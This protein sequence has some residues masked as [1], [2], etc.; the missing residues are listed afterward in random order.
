MANLHVNLAFSADTGKAKAQIQELQT[1]LSKIAYTGTTSNSLTGTMQKDIQAASSAAKDLQFHLNNAFNTTTGKF[2][3]SLLDR[4]LK[5]SGANITDLSTKLLG[6]G[7]TGQQAFMKL[8][9]SISLADQPMFRISN[10]MKEFAVTMKNT[11]KWQLSSSMLHGFMGAIQSAYGYAQDL[12]KSLTDIRIVTGYSADQMAV[13]A[14]RANKAAKSLSTTTTD[15]TNASLI[16][17]QQGLSD[18]EVAE[19]T[20]VT[21]KMANAAGESAQ[22]VSDQ[23]TAVWNNFYDGSKSLEYY[24]DVMTALG[25]ATASS[26]DEISEGLSK[27]AAVA[28]TVGLSYEY[29]TAAL[30]TITS[31]TR[32]SAD[33]VGNALKTLFARI[34]GLKLGETLEDGVNLNKYSEALDKA[35]I[36]IFESNGELKAMDDILTELASRWDTMSN[37]QQVALAQTVA[38][39][40]Q[41]TQLIALMENWDNG[42]AD[43]MMAN[44]RTIEGSEGALNEQADIYAQSWEAASKRVQ[45]AAQGIYQSLLD[46]DFFITLNNGFANLLGGIDA[47]IDG[48]GGLKTILISIAGVVMS[49]FANKIPAALDTLKYNLEVVTKGSQKAYERIQNQMNAATE[50]AFNKFNQTAGQQGIQKDSAMG[51]AIEQANELTAARN[52][53]AM[54]SDRMSAS[55]R[56]AADVQLGLIAAQQ[57]EVVALKEK[58]EALRASIELQR[59][60]IRN[61][62]VDSTSKSKSLKSSEEMSSLFLQY[63]DMLQNA[64]ERAGQILTIP[65]ADRTQRQSDNLTRLNA[66][67]EQYEQLTTATYNFSRNYQDAMQQVDST[68]NRIGQSLFQAFSSETFD[69]STE[70]VIQFSQEFRYAFDAIE[71]TLLNTNLDFNDSLNIQ[72]VQQQLKALQNTIPETVQQATGLDMAFNRVFSAMNEAELLDAFEYLQNDLANCTIEGNR[73]QTVLE[74]LYGRPISQISSDMRTLAANT[75]LANQKASILK[76][77]LAEF[78]PTHIVRMSEAMGALAGLM[79][80]IVTIGNSIKSIITSLGNPDLSGWEKFSA[81]LTGFSM[82]IPAVISGLRNATIA[83]EFLSGSFK[84]SALAM[85]ADAAGKTTNVVATKLLTAANTALNASFGPL[86]IIIA[87]IAAAILVAVLAFKALK[88]VIDAIH[89]SSFEGQLEAAEEATRGMAT[90]AEDATAAYQELLSTISGYDSAISALEGL[91]VGTQEFTN[92]LITA[93]EKAWELIDAYGLIQGQDWDYGENG[94]IIINDEAKNRITDQANE[95][96]EDAVVAASAAEI[97]EA[98]A[99]YNLSQSKAGMVGYDIQQGNLNDKVLYDA[100]GLTN[101]SFEHLK[102]QVQFDEYGN[103]ES[104]GVEIGDAVAQA[105]YGKDYDALDTSQLEYINNNIFKYLDEIEAMYGDYANLN[106]VSQNQRQKMISTSLS[107]EEAYQQTAWKGLI[108]E[109]LDKQ[110]DTEKARQDELFAA[111]TD[112]QVASDFAKYLTDQG[113]IQ[114]DDGKVYKK[115]ED[116]TQGDEVTNLSNLSADAQRNILATVEAMRTLEDQGVAMAEG[117]NQVASTMS[118]EEA[119]MADALINNNLGALTEEQIQQLKAAGDIK[120]EDLFDPQTLAAIRNNPVLNAALEG[121]LADLEKSVAEWE[122]PPFDLESWKADYAKKMDIINGLETGDEISAEDYALLGDEYAQYFQVQADGTAILIAKA[123]ELRA[124]AQ[125]IETDKLADD[126]R[127]K[128]DTIDEMNE[129]DIITDSGRT[130]DFNAAHN[131]ATRGTLH[132]TWDEAYINSV[133]EALGTSYTTVQEANAAYNEYVGSLSDSQQTLA[134]TADS[135]NDLD[136]MFAD[137]LI[138]MEQWSEATKGTVIKEAIAEGFEADEIINYAE[139]L[140]DAY[141]AT[142]ETE[143]EAYRLALAHKKQQKGLDALADGYEDWFKKMKSNG[144]DAVDALTEMQDA[145]ADILD[146]SKDDMKFLDKDFFLENEQLIKDA[147]TK[148]GEYIDQLREKASDEIIAKVTADLDETKAAE[149]TSKLQDLRT[150]AQLTLDGDPVTIGT[151]I[152]N[153]AAFDGLQELLNQGAM[154]ADEMN[155]FLASIGY[156]PVIEYDEMTVDEAI[157]SGSAMTQHVQIVD[158]MTGEIKEMTLQAASDYGGGGNT[159]V[160]VPRIRGEKTTYRGSGGGTS[161]K[162]KPS[163]G[164]GGGGNKTPKHAEKK[165]DSDKE[166]YHTIQNQLEDLKAEY[167]QIADAKDRAFGADKLKGIDEEIEKTQELIDKQEEYLDAIS[168]DLPI[169]KAIMD[170]YYRQLIGGNIE[171]DENGNIA[172]F[173]EIQDAMYKKYN[174]MADKYDEESEEWKVFE[175]KYEQLEKYIEQ[176]E[177]TYDLLRDEEAEYQELLNQ[178]LDLELEKIQYAIELKLNIA[179]DSLAL[180]EYQ[181]GR[182]EDDAFKAAEAVGLF[183]EQAELLYD[184][185]AADREGLN[186]ILGQQLS[187]AEIKMFY[188]GDMSVLEGKTFTEAQMEAIK[189]YRDNLLEL[190]EQFDEIRENVEEQV[191]EVFEAWNEQLD[192]G[193]EH[194]EHYGDVL[195]SYRNIID[196]VGED[197]LGISDEFMK[198]LNEAQIGNAIDKVNATKDAY[199]AMMKAQQE[200][201]K[202]LEEAK[203]RGDEASIKMWTENLAELTDEANSAQEEFLSAWEDALDTVAEQF[204][205]TVERVIESFNESIYALGGLE[206]LSEEFSRQQETADMMV[207]DYQ[208]IYELSKLNRDIQRTLDDTDVIAGKQKLL[209]LQEKINDLEAEGVE[210]SQYDLEYLQAEYELRMAEIELENA[211]KAKD[212]VRMSR[213]NEGNWSYVYTTN[214]DAVDEAQQKY[215]DALYAMQDLS[216]NYIDEMSEKLISTS[217]EME[218]A[219]A[220]LRIQDFASIDDYYAEVERIKKEYGEQLALEQ[221]ELQKAID[222]NKVLYDEDMAN[223]AKATGEK[224]RLAEE[225]VTSFKDSLLGSIMDSESESANFTDI[226]GSAVDDLTTGLMEA[227]TTYYQ[228]L[229]AAMNAADTSTGDF[230]EDTAANID[231]V[232]EKSKEGAEAIDQMAIEMTE[233]FQEIT[234]MVTNWQETYGMAM[235]KIIQSNLDVIDSFNQ[236]LEALSIDADKINVSYDINTSPEKDNPAAFDTG[237]YTGKWGDIGKL[238]VLHEKELILNE[239]DTS[240]FLKAINVSKVILDMIETNAKYASMGLGQITPTVVKE[241]TQEVL[242]QMVHIT[243]EFPGVQD[244]NEIEEAFKTLINT[245]SQYANRK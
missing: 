211:Q 144:P 47:F 1:L 204:E 93:N 27:F 87:A 171:Y 127:T 94:E 75:E 137:G 189:E 114:G 193:I 198:N 5:T 132:E 184:Q 188:E 108:T 7:A 183:A 175:K 102:G 148:G 79:G 214:T 73:F 66:E 76:T 200:A 10:R 238:A 63:N 24:A 225:F 96:R 224:Y 170:E 120:P 160:R 65:E 90:A 58:N 165:N 166:R 145:M 217:Q 140:M 210:M 226:I 195:E 174:S 105:L 167:E 36:S 155:A 205:M 33:V 223:Y 149:I 118:D 197:G 71:E 208:K 129:A 3:L 48:A 169:D 150:Q 54:V 31:N 212:T 229:E 151:Q 39:V 216:S 124:A 37:T 117:F 83:N 186:D 182:I 239:N 235:E 18:S 242:E 32:E 101:G 23:L 176:Y 116:G 202:A 15:Y 156:D 98:Q 147:A 119:A 85:V 190:N 201:E 13:F 88:W 141:E 62:Q 146:F 9:Q 50:Q 153:T 45:A 172:N 2:D 218:E 4:S 64:Q 6:A 42:D 180:L 178:R 126:I 161:S 237:G 162:P 35:G 106:N 187:A 215:E 196:I 80:N 74:G 207:D 125:G 92:A 139:A 104:V 100:L 222:N 138:T 112:E 177:E 115:N 107:D 60:N 133:N 8:A 109:E 56:Q 51:Y 135:V 77:L 158:P 78:Q 209:K 130:L 57:E 221:A 244:R 41:Y 128:Q 152:D 30:T 123:E 12:N 40:R 110:Y 236:M 159:V 103:L 231:A 44:L 97:A 43:S 19:R 28:E 46:D 55:E 240:N 143:E 173:D 191:M 95:R 34:Q 179:E 59:E 53:L 134:S 228:N 213:D 220:S 89:A 243:A 111:K 245:S 38:G 230:A 206:G 67:I 21:V 61:S 20:A 131:A 86:L 219:L 25:A 22:I 164:G 199:E 99:A 157:A 29:A 136:K 84:K 91:E 192:D 49:S 82:I 203:E 113:Y 26:T 14:E 69:E 122:P 121:W 17:F 72:M 11:V 227:A 81:V 232:V 168:A 233:A 181:M 70:Y 163:G 234:D 241:E 185:M 68:N 52:K 194:L 154:T 16:Y 142:V